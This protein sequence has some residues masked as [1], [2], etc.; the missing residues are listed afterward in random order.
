MLIELELEDY[1][2]EK[3]IGEYQ[4]QY[5]KNNNQHFSS[6]E[7]MRE[8]FEDG[9]SILNWFKKNELDILVEEDGI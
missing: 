3:F 4:K 8:F 7:E 2:Q 9:V 6:A 5:E 1:F